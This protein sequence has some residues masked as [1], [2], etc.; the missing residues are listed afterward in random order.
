MNLHTSASQILNTMILEEKASF[1]SRFS[2]R[3]MIFLLQHDCD[4]FDIIRILASSTKLEGY[5]YHTVKLLSKFSPR[6]REISELSLSN[7]RGMISRWTST[8]Y[9]TGPI[10]EVVA[11]IQKKCKE[12]EIGIHVYHSN[13]NPNNPRAAND[14]YV[15]IITKQDFRFLDLNRKISYYHSYIEKETNQ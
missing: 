6:T 9:H 4:F 3:F 5:K 13:L 7:I 14:T 8:K 1:P 15:L 11:N 12:K 2:L 10:D